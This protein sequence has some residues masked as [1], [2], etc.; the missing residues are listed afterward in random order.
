MRTAWYFLAAMASGF[1]AAHVAAQ[2]LGYPTKSVKIVIP[3]PPGGVQD[4]LA[5]AIGQELA[6]EWGQTV[7]TE[8][9]PGA[10]GVAAADA[11]AKSAPDG[12][13][14]FMADEVPLTI[15]PLLM[16]KLPYDPQADFVP[17]IALV[18]S[19]HVLA[20][21]AS[22]PYTSVREL[23]GAAR[24][25]PGSLNYGTFGAGSTGHLNTEELA[26]LAGIKVTHVPYKGGAD[27]LRALVAGDIQF[28]ITGLTPAQP[29]LKQGRLR[30]IA[31]TGTR[32]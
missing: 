24:A 31:Y 17:V 30:A 20:V 21:S 25:K 2:P 18:Q 1:G 5:R 15:T 7:L 3:V 23:I 4:L 27:V 6:R 22:S 14:I 26:T 10:G 32:R 8:N 19:S 11:V 13:T 29:L 12:H 9:R 28:A 16:S